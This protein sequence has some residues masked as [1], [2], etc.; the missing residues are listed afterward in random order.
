M[1]VYLTTNSPGE[2]ATWV[3]PVVAELERVSREPGEDIEVYVFVTPC[4]YA[5]GEEADVLATL[6]QVKRV[7]ST[8]QTARYALSGRAPTNFQHEGPGVLLFLGGE[9]KLAAWLAKRLGVPAFAY[10]EGFVNT[11]K[12]FERVFVPYESAA[13]K[14]K[15]HGAAAE[16]V[17][18][19]GNLMVDSVQPQ[20][21]SQEA[22]RQALG[23]TVA[24]PTV[25]ILPGS[26]KFEWRVLVPFYMEVLAQ[27]RERIQGLQSILAISPFS[28]SLKEHYGLA[29]EPGQSV[30]TRVEGES[31]VAVSHRSDLAIQAAD[32][33][34]TLPGSNTL[35]IAAFKRAMVV[36]LPLYHPEEIPLDGLAGMIGSIPIVG[37]PLKRWVVLK[38]SKRVP[39][40]A[41]PNR[42]AGKEIAPELRGESLQPWDVTT[43]AYQL[44]MADDV[45]ERVSMDLHAI[46]GGPGAAKAIVAD[47]LI[48]AR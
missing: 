43:V 46:V 21:T 45:R 32:L 31:I 26:R 48:R 4:R 35:E 3:R 39:F 7:F 47:M 41:L 13:V 38:Y 36:S 37:R 5:S 33:V 27:L 16:Q 44:L 2:V 9:M 12:A 23:L 34:L 25:A 1:R 24:T 8:E 18:V 15:R 20:V 19:V 6:P 29:L 17:R 22:A 14:A 30:Q 40:A 11:A 10:T 28:D 42:L